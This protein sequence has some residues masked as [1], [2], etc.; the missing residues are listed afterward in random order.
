MQIGWLTLLKVDLNS[1]SVD[2]LL[3]FFSVF[4]L[5]VAMWANNLLITTTL[6]VL[7]LYF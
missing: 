1:D 3:T 6:L 5:V 4:Q 7:L 2:R